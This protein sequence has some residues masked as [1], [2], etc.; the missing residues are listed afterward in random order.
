MTDKKFFVFRFRQKPTKPDRAVFYDILYKS[1][2]TDQNF[3]I[4]SNNFN[5]LDKLFNQYQKLF[6]TWVIYA[7]CVTTG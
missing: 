7:Y 3:V 4:L 1:F 6:V 2:T 5:N